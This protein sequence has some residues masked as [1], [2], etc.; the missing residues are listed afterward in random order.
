MIASTIAFARIIVEI[1]AVAPGI[2]AEMAPP[3]GI[4]LALMLLLSAGMYMLG[5]KNHEPMPEQG[6]PADLKSA[7]IFGAIY[8]LVILGVAAARDYFGEGGL[9]LVALISGLT[10][11]D[12][13]TLSTANLAN[14]DKLE[15]ST[16]WRIIL[17][18]A[19]ANLAFK[20]AMVGFLG[21]R[22]LLSRI[23][24]LFGAAI[25]GGVL[26]LLLWP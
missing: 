11:V 9:Y 14:Q 17:L 3:L 13:I 23:A 16:A 24:A 20:G 21:D 4:M 18:A 15:V 5:R 12:A 1:A 26:V 19:L 10:D 7:L 25:A 22:R 2:L 8:G 6:N